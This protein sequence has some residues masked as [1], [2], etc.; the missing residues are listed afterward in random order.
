MHEVSIC[1]SIVDTLQAELEE[2]QFQNVREVH[3]KVGV[4]SCVEPKNF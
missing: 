2:E 3:L 1:Q 4:L